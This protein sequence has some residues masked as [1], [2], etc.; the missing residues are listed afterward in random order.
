MHADKIKLRRSCLAL[1]L[2]FAGDA[3]RYPTI[4]TG[5]LGDAETIWTG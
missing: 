5:Q 1:H 2:Y 4:S 3:R